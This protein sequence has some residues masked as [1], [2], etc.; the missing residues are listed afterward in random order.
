MQSL[1]EQFQ[2]NFEVLYELY[3]EY[4][5]HTNISAIRDQEA[6]YQKHFV[7]S[8]YVSKHID[9]L[10]AKSI[11]DL[12]SGGGFPALPLAIVA[13][14]NYHIT[15]VDSVG[16]KTKFIT[17]VKEEL[18]LRNLTVLTERIEDLG[19]QAKHRASYDLVLARAVAKLNILLEFA[20][21]LLKIN[22]H[23]IAFKNADIADELL[24]AQS[25]IEELGVELIEQDYYQDK[26]LLVF[27]KLK[28]TNK[29]Y[30]RNNQQIKQNPL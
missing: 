18:D 12:G 2:K 19:Q 3:N 14:D 17:L 13:Q 25:T 26:Q 23:F 1:I 7:D 28:A 9:K 24:E 30:P 22:G 5:A 21:P 4:N 20:I 29:L 27:K 16:K 15:A 10:Q 6:I 8:L 11:I